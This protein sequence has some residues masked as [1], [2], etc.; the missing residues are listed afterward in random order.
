MM[1]MRKSRRWDSPP[2]SIFGA[3]LPFGAKDKMRNFFKRRQRG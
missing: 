2:R 3:A 1:K